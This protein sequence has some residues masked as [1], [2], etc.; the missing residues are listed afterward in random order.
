MRISLVPSGLSSRGFSTLWYRSIE[1]GDLL[2]LRGRDA[3]AEEIEGALTLGFADSGGL[4]CA[5]RLRR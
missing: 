5:L 4:F 3:A 2:L 1:D